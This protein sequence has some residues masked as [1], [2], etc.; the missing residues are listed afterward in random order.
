MSRRLGALGLTLAL[1]AVLAAAVIPKCA[2]SLCCMLAGETRVKAQMPCCEPSIS[3]DDVRVQPLK[4][5]DRQ[6]CLSGQAGLPVLHHAAEIVAVAEAPP[7]S[8]PAFSPP[9]FLLNAQFLI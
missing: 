1:L 5:E 2:D 4:V 6:S 9:L 3:Q 8:P 7:P